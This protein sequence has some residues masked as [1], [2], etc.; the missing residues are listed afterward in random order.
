MVQILFMVKHEKLPLNWGDAEPSEAARVHERRG[1]MRLVF[2]K[3]VTQSPHFK[4]I[5]GA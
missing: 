3:Y 5:R 4:A 1:E 2:P